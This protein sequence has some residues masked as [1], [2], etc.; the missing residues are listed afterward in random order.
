MVETYIGSEA[1]LLVIYY[2]GSS[3]SAL[4]YFPSK[5]TILFDFTLY[6]TESRKGITFLLEAVAITMF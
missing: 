2:V 6:P 3:F 1:V 5:P 4:K